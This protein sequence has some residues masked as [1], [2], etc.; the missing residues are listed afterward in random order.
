MKEVSIQELKRRLSTIVSEAAAGTEYMITRHK[1]PV[2]RV[3]P[4]DRKHLH[5]GSRFG[6]GNLKPL[7]NAKTKGRYLQILAEDRDETSDE[8]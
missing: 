4:A 5:Q 7:L 2:A 3:S 6:K 8:H 1:R